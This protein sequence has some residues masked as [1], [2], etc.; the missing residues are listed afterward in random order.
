MNEDILESTEGGKHIILNLCN[1][2]GLCTR[3]GLDLDILR[4]FGSGNRT[5]VR[6][7]CYDCNYNNMM[8]RV[9]MFD[10]TQ[11]IRIANCVVKYGL[12][13]VQGRDPIDYYALDD[14]LTKILPST[15][16]VHVPKCEI[17]Q[18]C[19]NW[20]SVSQSLAD[21]ANTTTFII[22]RVKSIP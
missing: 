17:E 21:Y 22:N 8:G 13:K 9:F 2:R 19:G 16:T 12:K 15:S 11:D 4:A 3:Y 5:F 6:N 14:A 1:D 20:T 7:K 18:I 10:V